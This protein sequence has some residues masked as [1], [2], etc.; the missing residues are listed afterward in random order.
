MRAEAQ[1]GTSLI[2]WGVGPFGLARSRSPVRCAYSQ[3][4]R[5]HVPNRARRGFRN[6]PEKVET[7]VAPSK[8]SS[9]PNIANT[10]SRRQKSRWPM[11]KCCAAGR[12]SLGVQ[13]RCEK[14]SQRC[15]RPSVG[16]AVATRCWAARARHRR[17]VPEHVVVPFAAL[18]AS[19][20]GVCAC[21][22]RVAHRQGSAASDASAAPAS[23]HGCVQRLVAL[24]APSPVTTAA[25]PRR[26]PAAIVFSRY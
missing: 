6:F 18:A 5:V 11:N 24:C 26:S 23:T 15:V 12:S 16:I 13:F 22:R 9:S 4:W 10:V 2:F 7:T 17:R 21:M 25:R 1:L 8:H 20:V 14:N 19:V 3:T